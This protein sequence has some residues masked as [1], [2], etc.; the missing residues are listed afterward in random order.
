MQRRD[1]Q[2]LR[3]IS[4]APNRACRQI[5]YS[6]AALTVIAIVF[7]YR[8][9]PWPVTLASIQHSDRALPASLVDPAALAP[10]P[11]EGQLA[12]PFPW[13]GGNGGSGDAFVSSGG[14]VSA[15]IEAA[16]AALYEEQLR[17]RLFVRPARL[18]AALDALNALLP[19]LRR[20]GHV[21]QARA[22]PSFPG[23]PRR[24]N[25]ATQPP[26]VLGS[27]RVTCGSPPAERGG[28]RAG[29]HAGLLQPPRTCHPV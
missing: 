20:D 5:Q 18:L 4:P 24:C 23:R 26:G 2:S 6:L 1:R 17:T 8:R 11:D 14:G 9:E 19:A 28:G 13:S 25:C 27:E 15:F 21:L 29:R 12:F 16:R 22:R 7:F 10:E 3:L